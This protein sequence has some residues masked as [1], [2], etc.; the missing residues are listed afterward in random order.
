LIARGASRATV[1]F[2]AAIA[3]L[4]VSVLL[5]ACS[6]SDTVSTSFDELGGD[7]SQRVAVETKALSSHLPLPSPILDVHVFVET[8][9]DGIGGPSDHVTFRQIQVSP[10]D[11]AQ[12]TRHLSAV[13]E[14]VTFAAPP[15]HRSWWVSPEA[16]RHLAFYQPASPLSDTAHG[17]IGVSPADGQI[18]AFSYSM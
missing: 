16:F 9:G 12:W 4:L 8:L 18:F 14:P 1:A 3:A 6:T 10:G 15:K 13:S 11:L 5:Q 7:R 2:K 17:W